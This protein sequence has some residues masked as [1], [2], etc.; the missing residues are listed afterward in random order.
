MDYKFYRIEKD[1]ST[2]WIYLNR[3]EKKNAMNPPAFYELPQIISEMDKDTSI[4]VIVIASSGDT[5]SAGIDLTEM[6]MEIE[7][8]RNPDQKGDTKWSLIKK[9]YRLQDMVNCLQA[10]DKPVIAAVNGLCIGAGLDLISGCDIRLC[11]EDAKFS[12]REAA[13]GFVA[14]IGVLQRLPPIIG[15]GNTRELAFTAKFIDAKTALRMHLVN[16]VFENKD[17]LMKGALDMALE[18]A[19]VSPLAVKATKRVLNF[20]NE[21]RIKRGLEYVA[22]VSADII[23][24]EDLYEAINAFIEKR[25]PDFKGR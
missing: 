23:P 18:I 25:K 3:A 21:E 4:R 2:G 15:E 14:D 12:L 13:V 11:S 20:L 17:S 22:S 7:E 5:F 9:I 24:S 8:I 6:S 16:A 1:K 10:T 19:S